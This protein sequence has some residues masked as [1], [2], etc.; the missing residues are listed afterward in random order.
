MAEAT[1]LLAGGG[2]AGHVN[3]LL[4]V[5]DALRAQRPGIGLVALGTAE[6][7]ES[8]LVPEHGLELALVP[9]VPLPRRPTLDWLRLPGRLRAAVR[10]A[11]RAIDEGGAVVVVGFGGYVSTPAYLAARRRR[12]PVVVHEQNAR[13]G[14]ANRLGARWAAAVATTFPATRLPRAQVT[15]LP[16]RAPIA[17]LVAALPERR[18]FFSALLVWSGARIGVVKVAHAARQAGTTKYNF[19]KLL[20]HTFDLLVG[21]SSKPL[22]YIGTLGLLCAIFGFG[23]GAWAI[24]RKVFWDYGMMGWPS[25]F[26]AVVVLSGMQLMALSVIGEYIEHSH[27]LVLD[28]LVWNGIPIG[29]LIILALA[30][31]FIAH[32]RACR[33]RRL[34]VRPR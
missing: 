11:G 32:I 30:W 18:K 22:R 1:V 23:L 34:P 33:N 2:T 12:V 15:G 19:T 16:L 25:L 31:W 8:R 5:A 9:R 26:A 27:N 14:L 21:F 4:A 6:G 7:L 13:P 10:A 17:R 20:N 29:G 24:A 3:P 28:L